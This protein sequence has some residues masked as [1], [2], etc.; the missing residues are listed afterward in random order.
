MVKRIVGSFFG[1][2]SYGCLWMVAVCLFSLAGQGVIF[3]MIVDN[4]A[5]QAVASM[6]T[7]LAFYMPT[8]VYSSELLAL[9]QKTMIHLGTGLIVYIPTAFVMGWIPVQPNPVSV[10]IAVVFSFAISIVIWLV[11]YI[12]FRI[13]AKDANRINKKIKELQQENKA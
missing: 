10:A 6:V 12:Y 3:K 11:F 8:I 1:G 5:I 7:G 9:W 13:V 4:F 2:I